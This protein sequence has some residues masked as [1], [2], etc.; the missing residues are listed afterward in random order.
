[1][2]NKED[3]LYA[4]LKAAAQGEPIEA[5]VIGTAG[6]DSNVSKE[7]RNR[8]LTWKEAKKLLTYGFYSGFGSAGCDA[9]YAWTPTKILFVHQYDGATTLKAVPRHPGVCEPDYL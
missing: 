6:Y 1:M 8:L 7:F 2:D 9:V 5:V 3:T 4:W